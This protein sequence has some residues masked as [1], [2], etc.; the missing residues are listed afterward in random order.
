MDWVFVVWQ[1]ANWARLRTLPADLNPDRPGRRDQ[2]PPS[3]IDV[4]AGGNIRWSDVVVPEG[5]KVIDERMEAHGFT[6]AD[7]VV[8]EGKVIDLVTHL[9]VAAWMRLERVEPQPKGGYLY[10][11]DGRGDHRRTK[12]AGS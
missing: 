11:A 6:P 1:P 9:P 5:L 10:K 3:L 2:G 12:A 4:Y 8:L 7:G